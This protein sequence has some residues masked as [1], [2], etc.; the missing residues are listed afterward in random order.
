MR[1]LATQSPTP[2][3]ALASAATHLEKRDPAVSEVGA[4]MR[5]E[6]RP[7]RRPVPTPPVRPRRLAYGTYV[8]VRAPVCAA[9]SRYGCRLCPR[10]PPLTDEWAG[11]RGN[12][13]TL[14]LWTAGGMRYAHVRACPVWVRARRAVLL[15]C[16]PHAEPLRLGDRGPAYLAS[17]PVAQRRIALAGASRQGRAVRY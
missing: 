2:T 4:T 15:P 5:R 17:G 7:S 13:P 1:T 16:T 3:P 6:R 8:L 9:S 11:A 12:G 14:P 10:T